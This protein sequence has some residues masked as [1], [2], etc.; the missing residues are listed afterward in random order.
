M[1]LGRFGSR[2]ITCTGTP[3]DSSH[4][5]ATEMTPASSPLTLG[6]LMRLVAASMR[7]ARAA[8]PNSRSTVTRSII[9][10][11]PLPEDRKFPRSQRAS[12]DLV[13]AV[14]D[15]EVLLDVE[16]PEICREVG[17]AGEHH[18]RL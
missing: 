5:W 12:Q 10:T 14:G 13:T 18:A 4:A 15:D 6:T 17:V 9:E 1:R 3:R 2:A 8:S 7:S 11:S 16:E